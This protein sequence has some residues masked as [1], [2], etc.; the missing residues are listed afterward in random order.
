MQNDVKIKGSKPISENLSVMTVGD[1]TT[2]LEISDRN[3][4]RVTGD[5][6]VT[7]DIKGNITDITFDDITFDDI[8]CDDITCDDILC[9]K[10]VTDSITIDGTEID[11]SGDLTLDVQGDI[12]LDHGSNDEVKLLE[13][14]SDFGAIRI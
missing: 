13:D 3:G 12:S 5:L 9:N 7:G 2:C 11:S 1:Q 14:G 8:T 10:I 6:E 4:A